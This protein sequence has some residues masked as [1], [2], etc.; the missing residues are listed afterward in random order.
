[1]QQK[2]VIKM[3]SRSLLQIVDSWKSGLIPTKIPILG[4]FYI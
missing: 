1:M 4:F 2:V 3:V